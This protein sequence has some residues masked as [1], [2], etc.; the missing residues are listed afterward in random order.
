MAMTDSRGGPVSC[1]YRGLIN[2]VEATHEAV[3]SFVGSPVDDVVSL[4]ADNLRFVIRYWFAAL[5]NANERYL[6]DAN[7]TMTRI[8]SGSH[9]QRDVIAWTLAKAALRVQRFKLALALANERTKLRPTSPHNW[10]L[11]ARSLRR[12]GDI[13]SAKAHTHS[14]S[15]N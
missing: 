1:Y 7:V 5:M 11:T 14:I 2:A 12:M 10:R 8:V 9:A 6:D 4:L 15:Q 13:A 3:L